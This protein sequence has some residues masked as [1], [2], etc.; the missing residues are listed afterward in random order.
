MNGYSNCLQL[1][2]GLK[3]KGC[4]SRGTSIMNCVVLSQF[5]LPLIFGAPPSL[6]DGGLENDFAVVFTGDSL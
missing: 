1:S 5:A 6:L 4:C 3:R 2:L